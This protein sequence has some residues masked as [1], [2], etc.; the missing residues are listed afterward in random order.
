LFLLLIVLFFVTPEQV[1]VVLKNIREFIL[2]LLNKKQLTSP[3]AACFAAAADDVAFASFGA[4]VDVVDTAAPSGLRFGHLNC[5][6]SPMYKILLF[7]I[8]I[9]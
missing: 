5:D 8:S 6:P 2:K 7:V 3:P 4:E 9:N 1:K